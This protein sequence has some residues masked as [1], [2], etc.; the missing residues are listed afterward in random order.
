MPASIYFR[1]MNF[2]AGDVIAFAGREWASRAIALGTCK[3]SQLLTGRWISHMGV[4]APH[5]GQA[6]LFESTTF[7]DMPCAIREE[8]VNGVQAHNPYQRLAQYEGR[9]WIMRPRKRVSEAQA[10]ALA[11]FCLGSIN[12]P[13]D[14]RQAVLSAVPHWI[15]RLGWIAP[16]QSLLFC[17]ELVSMA[18]M[19]AQIIGHD[20]NPSKATPAWVA[21]WLVDSWQFMPM[22]RLTDKA[23]W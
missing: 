12:A 15:K 9:A 10:E 3:F 4:I 20:Y 7:T 19:D 11:A 21:W 18:L 5:D 17:D 6:L 8:R 14:Y 2:L 1:D 22:H 13:Y 23:I 16:D